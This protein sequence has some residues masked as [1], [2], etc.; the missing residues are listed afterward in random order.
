MYSTITEL[1]TAQ[2]ATAHPH[3]LSYRLDWLREFWAKGQSYWTEYEGIYQ[4]MQ[5]QESPIQAEYERK[6][7][8]AKPICFPTTE[9]KAE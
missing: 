4:A 1:C 6:E 3:G 7:C 9:Q 8:M 2:A 5:T